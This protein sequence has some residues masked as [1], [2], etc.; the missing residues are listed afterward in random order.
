M[1]GLCTPERAAAALSAALARIEQMIDGNE[2]L[3]RATPRGMMLTPDGRSWVTEQLHAERAALDEAAMAACYSR[4]MELN[5][6][7][8]ALVSEW[9][10]AQASGPGDA[11]WASVVDRVAAVDQ[12]LQPVLDDAC[13]Q[14]PRLRTYRSRFRAALEAMRAG[15]HTML[16]APLK[17]SYHT[18]WFEYHEE[19][20]TLCGRDRATDERAEVASR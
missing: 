19:L 16:A 18:A 9:Q 5:H 12:G 15:D 7:F 14:V 8:K 1:K 10:L 13:G 17:D 4:F 3:F 20:I 2:T 11:D 6:T